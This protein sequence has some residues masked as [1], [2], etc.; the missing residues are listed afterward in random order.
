MGKNF[1][2]HE[3]QVGFYEPPAST[4]PKTLA[5][6]PRYQGSGNHMYSH[7]EYTMKEIN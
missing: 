6:I 5:Q 7:W 3:K 4:I 1:C 2:T